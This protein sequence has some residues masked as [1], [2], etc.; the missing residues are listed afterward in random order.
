MATMRGYYRSELL[1]A[2]NNIEMALTHLVRLVL[3]YAEAHPDIASQLDDVCEGLN[4]A[5]TVIRK[6]HDSI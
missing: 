4:L 5:I 2:I 1:R 6:I 3:A